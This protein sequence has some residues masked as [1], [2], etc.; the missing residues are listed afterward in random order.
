MIR[1]IKVNEYNVP[2][3]C[4]NSKKIEYRLTQILYY[5]HGNVGL[6]KRLMNCSKVCSLLSKCEIPEVSVVLVSVCIQR[7]QVAAQQ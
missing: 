3:D 5:S 7:V 1:Q 6:L 2:I 4:V